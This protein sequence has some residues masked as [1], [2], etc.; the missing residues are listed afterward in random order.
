MTRKEAFNVLEYNLRE[1][2]HIFAEEESNLVE[3]MLDDFADQWLGDKNKGA[4]KDAKKAAKK[5]TEKDL[6]EIKN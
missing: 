3:E 1:T 6:K 5:A 2:K 4:K